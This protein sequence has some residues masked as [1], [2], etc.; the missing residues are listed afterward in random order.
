MGRPLRSMIAL[1]A[2]VVAWSTVSSSAA[3]TPA[4]ARSRSKPATTARAGSSG[5]LATFRKRGG[6]SG[7]ARTKSVNVPPMSNATRHMDTGS[8]LP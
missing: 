5:L 7:P 2:T 3:A 6:V 1:V 4:S 8:P